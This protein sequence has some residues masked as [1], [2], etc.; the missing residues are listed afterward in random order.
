[1]I[2]KSAFQTQLVQPRQET[3]FLQPNV[4][5]DIS[6]EAQLPANAALRYLAIRPKTAP[7]QTSTGFA[8]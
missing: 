5:A 7:H 2:T 8:F 3:S 4:R 6:L 1:M